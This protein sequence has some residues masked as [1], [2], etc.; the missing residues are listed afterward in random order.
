MNRLVAAL[1]AVVASAAFAATDVSHAK[2]VVVRGSADHMEQVL[3]QAKV[4]FVAVDPEE[5]PELALNAKQV[6]MVN[7][8]G[9]MSEQARER[10]RRFVAAG[11][12]LYT[13]DHAV[14]ELIE[15]LFPNTIAFAGTTEERVFPV[16]VRGTDEDRGLLSSL[17]GNA[18]EMWQTAGGGYTFKILDPKRVT[19]LMDSP[20]IARAFGSGLVAAR[21][22]YEDGQVI[23]VTGH[24]F[25]QP[26]QQPSEDVASAGQGFTRFS[27]N[28]TAAK[29]ADAP[30]I[31]GLFANKAK[32]E[33]QLQAEP[34]PAAPA[35]STMGRGAGGAQLQRGEQLRVLEKKGGY[36]K[37]RDEQGNEGWVSSDAL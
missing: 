36:A 14:K 37:V 9:E 30:R 25:T 35:A 3:T 28:V 2:V 33:V 24:F 27:A 5:L 22:R 12:F 6:L 23:H 10:V 4:K 21:F 19:V 16:K 11:G 8:T 7:C 20:Q 26:G 13:T 34:A 17:G 32:R 15:P 29:E 18:K 31:D 1:L